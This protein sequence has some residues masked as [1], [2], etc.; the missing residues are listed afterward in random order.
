MFS[1]CSVRAL[2]II[3]QFNIKCIGAFKAEDYPRI[4]PDCNRPETL[5]LTLQRMQSIPRKVQSLRRFSFVEPGENI[6]DVVEQIRPYP[7]AIVALVQ[8]FEAAMLE[9]SNDLGYAVKCTLSLV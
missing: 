2:V 7:P 5:Q 3:R 4:R 1:P 9:A 8:P 6:F